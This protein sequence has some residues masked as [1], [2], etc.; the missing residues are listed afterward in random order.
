MIIL[1]YIRS[2][3]RY[4]VAARNGAVA[5]ENG[6]KYRV[7]MY[8]A[9]NKISPVADRELKNGSE[10]ISTLSDDSIPLFSDEVLFC[11]CS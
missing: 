10:F 5:K 4:T 11:G 7:R 6:T 9:V 3:K 1:V 8:T 2:P